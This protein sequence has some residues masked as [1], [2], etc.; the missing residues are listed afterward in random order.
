[1]TSHQA[2]LI[3]LRAA[4]PGKVKTRLAKRLG[5]QLVFSLYKNFVEDTLATV[6][7]LKIPARICFYPPEKKNDITSWLGDHYTYWGQSGDHLGQRMANAFARTFET[8]VEH[9]VLIGTD[10]PDLPGQIIEEAFDALYSHDAAIGPSADGGYYL[11]G[12]SAAGFL[13]AIFDGNQWGQPDVFARTMAIFDR[14]NTSVHLS[15]IWQDIDE[16]EDLLSFA[17][18]NAGNAA[19]GKNTA[20]L[21]ARCIQFPG[22]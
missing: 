9:A 20:A 3:F 14:H 7:A 16:V 4:E 18:R 17:K 19:A 12:F 15:P 11:I 10:I 1:M 2:I 22:A 21:I 8:G 6:R 13:P 5:T